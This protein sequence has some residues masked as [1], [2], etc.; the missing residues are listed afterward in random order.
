MVMN[1]I[2]HINCGVIQGFLALRKAITTHE[3]NVVFFFTCVNI[4]NQL[5]TRHL[6]LASLGQVDE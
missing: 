6:P 5:L 3:K 1:F 2:Y 4:A